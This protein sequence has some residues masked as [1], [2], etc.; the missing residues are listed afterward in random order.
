MIYIKNIIYIIIDVF[1]NLI[2]SRVRYGRKYDLR[3]NNYEVLS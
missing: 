1:V 3:T 2:T